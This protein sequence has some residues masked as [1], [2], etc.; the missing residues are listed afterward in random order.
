MVKRV[1]L[2]SVGVPKRCER[3]YGRL[4]IIGLALA[5]C[6]ALVSV[7][8]APPRPRLI[9]NASA[10]VPVGRYWLEDGRD[11][12]RADTVLVWLLAAARKLAADRG[13]L[14]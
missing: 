11:L 8:I 2:E 5:I 12:E 3:R 7:H 14:P 1:L 4:R 6:M 9:W 10:S 13:Y